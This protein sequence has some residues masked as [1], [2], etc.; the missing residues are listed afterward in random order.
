MELSMDFV[1]LAAKSH[2][3]PRNLA[4]GRDRPPPAIVCP[5]PDLNG[6][7]EPPHLFTVSPVRIRLSEIPLSY[8]AHT[9]RLYGDYDNIYPSTRSSRPDGELEIVARGAPARSCSAPVT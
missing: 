9:G 7:G 4:T 6:Q 8:I 5:H 3:G 2:R 1:K